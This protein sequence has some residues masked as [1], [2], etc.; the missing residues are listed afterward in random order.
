MYEKSF[1]EPFAINPWGFYSVGPGYPGSR[2]YKEWV[3][4]SLEK[5]EGIKWINECHIFYVFYLNFL[6]EGVEPY[7]VSP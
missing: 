7:I 1:L 3:A 5:G 2:G 4:L 6:S